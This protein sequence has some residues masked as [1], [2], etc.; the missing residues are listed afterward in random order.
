MVRVGTPHPSDQAPEVQFHLGDHLGSS[1]VVIDNTGGWINREEYTPYGESTFGSFAQKRYRFTGKERDEESG[2][3]YHGARYYAPWIARWTSCDPVG[4]EGGTQYYCYAYNNPIRFNDP[5]GCL[6]A[7]YEMAE[8]W[9]KSGIAL[10]P[11]VP[12][13]KVVGA[14]SGLGDKIGGAIVDALPNVGGMLAATVVKTAFDVGGGIVGAILDPGMPVR[15]VMRFGTGSAQGVQDI[16]NGNT[17]L[18]VS[19]IVGEGAQGVGIVLGGVSAAR[20]NAVPGTFG[21]PRTPPPAAPTPQYTPAAP[22]PE[23]AALIPPKPAASPAAPAPKRMHGNSISG[24]NKPHHVYEIH[25]SANPGLP[26]KSG[27]S[28]EP[29]NK[30]GTSPRAAKQVNKLNRANPVPAGQPP[31]FS[32]K[33]VAQDLPNRTTAL[34]FEQYLV[35]VQKNTSGAA[36]AGNIRPVPNLMFGP[37]AFVRKK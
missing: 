31:R 10:I 11:G 4:I 17:V 3:Y 23:A 6:P 32:Q 2:L 30:N 24:N 33:V 19:R 28:G 18:G 35:N 8:A 9:E 37:G 1:S 20:L 16:E 13:E 21:N 27:V 34:S 7:P 12:G 14:A 36:G 29:L 25:D 26:N 22:P 5:D 15:N